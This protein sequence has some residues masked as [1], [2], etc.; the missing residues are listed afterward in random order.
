[1]TGTKPG[2]CVCVLVSLLA[3]T[4]LAVHMLV[5]VW[6]VSLIKDKNRGM[7][8][9]QQTNITLPVQ[10]DLQFVL[11]LRYASGVPK[12]FLYVA[13]QVSKSRVSK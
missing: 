5:N 12:R 4:L 3:L 8:R 10:G 2:L 11:G 1:M 6:L 9:Q 13:P 7:G